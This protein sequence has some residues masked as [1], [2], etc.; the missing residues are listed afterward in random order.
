[1]KVST[2]I[3]NSREQFYKNGKGCLFNSLSWLQNK[4]RQKVEGKENNT[5]KTKVG[6]DLFAIP[7]F[8]CFPLFNTRFIYSYENV[9]QD[10]KL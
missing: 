1:M 8:V 3:N 10:K 6:N 5:P 4:I 7:K 2:I 9:L